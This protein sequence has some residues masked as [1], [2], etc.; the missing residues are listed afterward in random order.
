LERYKLKMMETQRD[1]EHQLEQAQREAREAQAELMKMKVSQEFKKAFNDDGS[2]NET[3]CSGCVPESSFDST[4]SDDDLPGLSKSREKRQESMHGLDLEMTNNMKRTLGNDSSSANE[5]SG[6][7]WLPDSSSDC[8]ESDDEPPGMSKSRNETRD[9]HGES[10]QGLDK[11]SSGQDAFQRDNVRWI[12]SSRAR[13]KTGERVWDKVHYCIFCNKGYKKVV[14]HW[15]K[16]HCEEAEVGSISAL[17]I[18]SKERRSLIA[19][20]RKCGDYEHNSR[21]LG[22]S[23]EG[24]LVVH[25]R[26]K[27][28]TKD[29]LNTYNFCSGCKGLYKKAALYRHAKKCKRRAKKRENHQRSGAALMPV[30]GTVSEKL[31]VVFLGMQSDRLTLIA[32]NDP[33]IV[34]LGEYYVNSAGH[35]DNYRNY[36]SQKMREASRLLSQARSLDP[37]IQTAKDLI[38]PENFEVVMSAT[39]ECCSFNEATATYET[40]SLARKLG[41]CLTRIADILDAESLKAGVVNKHAAGFKRLMALEWGPRISS[42]ALRQASNEKWT[43]PRQL[44]L[45]NDIMKLNKYVG[46]QEKHVKTRIT[47]EGINENSFADLA[48]CALTQVVLYNRRRPGEMQ[49]LKVHTYK[50]RTVHGRSTQREVLNSLPLSEQVAIDRLSL[51]Y[52]RGKRDRGV[53]VL[54]TQNMKDSLDILA[55]ET[56]RQKAGG[57]GVKVES[58]TPRGFSGLALGWGQLLMV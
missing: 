5:T 39:Y 29:N 15:F 37:C 14:E 6:S 9:P 26:P 22:G 13:A 51:I 3:S 35:T 33:M 53:S 20:L 41:H 10:V 42:H 24:P 18:G 48:K 28:G 25:K 27:F 46:E 1:L 47:H 45:T 40:P 12:G 58:L 19:K 49:F 7:E 4:N 44:P 23:E 56:N 52:I 50:T 32:R 55:N 17:Q 36:V 8:T 31:K 43:N 57:K 54:L 11:E 38:N 30:N 21:V 16:K 34:K 2:A